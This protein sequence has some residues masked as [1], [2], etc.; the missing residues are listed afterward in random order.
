M[1]NHKASNRTLGGDKR[2]DNLVTLAPHIC[3]VQR[4]QH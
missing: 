1:W 2:G 4:I 3:R